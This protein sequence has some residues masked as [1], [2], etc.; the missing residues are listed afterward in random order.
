MLV[1]IGLRSTEQFLHSV[2]VALREG[3]L[4]LGASKWKTIATVVVP[5][6]V[7]GILTGMILG[8]ARIAGETAPAAVHGA[9]QPVLEFRA[10]ISRWRR[11]RS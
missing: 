6:A 9:E 10:S 4:A 2:P 8:V 1:P 5:A 11:C 3:A 7:Q